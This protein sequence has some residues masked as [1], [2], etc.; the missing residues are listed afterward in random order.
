MSTVA[1]RACSCPCTR[2][3]QQS[4]V[5]R[6]ISVRV[7]SQRSSHE[8][9]RVLRLGLLS[10]HHAGL[11]ALNRDPRLVSVA[12]EPLKNIDAADLC[13]H[14]AP[15]SIGSLRPASR[16]RAWLCRIFLAA[17]KK[18]EAGKCFLAIGQIHSHRSHPIPDPLCAQRHCSTAPRSPMCHQNCREHA[19][20]HFTMCTD[21]KIKDAHHNKHTSWMLRAPSQHSIGKL[22]E[23]FGTHELSRWNNQFHCQISNVW[24][25][26]ECWL[27]KALKWII[28]CSGSFPAPCSAQFCEKRH[29][30][31]RRLQQPTT[32]SL[33]DRQN[34]TSRTKQ[35]RDV[36]LRFE[37]K[38]RARR[39][40]L[41]SRP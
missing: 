5:V 16:S 11:A 10:R 3:P 19:S 27:R 37:K 32:I 39:E 40:T 33:P 1:T 6:P 15:M 29:G 21:K 20:R 28:I 4:T 31:D 36:F 14:T 34:C 2:S 12:N 24:S 41:S 13:R 9:L 22:K 30:P 17:E 25:T 8:T 26:R 38:L 35:S 7:P 23:P 18:T